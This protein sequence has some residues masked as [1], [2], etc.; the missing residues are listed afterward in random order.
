DDNQG[1]AAE[2]CVEMWRGPDWPQAFMPQQAGENTKPRDGQREI[3]EAQ[4][5]ALLTVEIMQQRGLYLQRDADK[6]TQATDPEEGRGQTHDDLSVENDFF[7]IGNGR[8]AFEIDWRAHQHRQA[9]DDGKKQPKQTGLHGN[10]KGCF[11][12]HTEKAET[13]DKRTFADTP[14]AE[15]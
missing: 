5:Q 3:G 12:W 9:E 4:A 14:S 1:Q 13:I 15:T 7:E 10:Q 8:Q 11:R 2:P 6:E